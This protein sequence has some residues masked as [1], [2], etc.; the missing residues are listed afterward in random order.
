[1]NKKNL[2]TVTIVAAAVAAYFFRENAPGDHPG[3]A[4][5]D[6]PRGA[7]IVQVAMPA[8]LSETARMGQRAFDAKCASC[9][10]ADAAGQ[11]GV[12][13]P[14]I[15][16]IYEPGHHADMSFLMAAQRGVRSHHW[17]FGDMPPVEGVTDADVKMIVRYIREVQQV[18]GIF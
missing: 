14:L 2:A 13:P 12:A 7:A 6:P 8:T 18:N 9:H 3:S 1:M 4:Q 5:A 10:G 11:K 17:P 15:H 16:K